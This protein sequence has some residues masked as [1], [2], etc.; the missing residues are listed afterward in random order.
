MYVIEV[1]PLH[2]GQQ[3]GTLSYFSSVPYARGGVITI[4]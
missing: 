2:V 3:V 4:P 1:I